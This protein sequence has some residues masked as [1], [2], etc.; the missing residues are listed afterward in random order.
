MNQSTIDRPLRFYEFPEDIGRTIFEVLAET[1]ENSGWVCATVS[2]KVKSWCIAWSDYSLNTV[3]LG[4][5]GRRVEP[6]TSIRTSTCLS[7]IVP[8][9]VTHQRKPISSRF[10]SRASTY[11]SPGSPV[12]VTL[13]FWKHV[14]MSNSST[15]GFKSGRT[16]VRMSST[17]LE[18]TPFGRWPSPRCCISVALFLHPMPISTSSNL[19]CLPMSRISR[20]TVHPIALLIGPGLPPASCL[21]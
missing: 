17:G 9:C 4:F 18:G 3:Y 19:R 10:M 13:I 1:H 16:V 6:S 5:C 2:K 15:Y 21:F 8:S 12:M 7:F 11:P 20:L 14:A